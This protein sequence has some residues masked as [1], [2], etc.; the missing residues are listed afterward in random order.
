VREFL[1][2]HAPW[3]ETRDFLRQPTEAWAERHLAPALADRSIE[4]LWVLSA[5]GATVFAARRESTLAVPAPPTPE[6]LARAAGRLGPIQYFVPGPGGVWQVE[7]APVPSSGAT[8]G[9]LVVARRWDAAHVARLG[10][11]ADAV[12]TVEPAGGPG[13]GRDRGWRRALPD[14]DG[15]PVATAVFRPTRGPAPDAPLPLGLVAS[16]FVAFAGALLGGLAIA[17]NRWVLHPLRLV[18]RSLEG[19][20]P[21]P[22]APLRAVPGEFRAVAD[23]VAQA[24]EQRAALEQAIAERRRA[25]A[26]LR[27]S[28]ASLRES[29]ELRS[30]L[31]R[32][33]H[34]HVIQSI[35]A[36]GLGLESV[37]NAMSEDPFGA[38]GRLRHCMDNLNETIRQVR[39]YIS[40]LEPDPGGERQHLTEALR[41]LAETMRRLWPMAIE[42]EV[43]REAA[44]GWSNAAE[45]HALQIV[46]ESLSNALRH[47][48][49]GRVV[50]SLRR[51]AGRPVLRVRDDGAGFDPV[52]RLGTGR[53]LVN[54]ATRARE[55]GAELAVE[56]QPGAGTTVVVRLA[57]P[58]RES[59]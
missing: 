30:R 19:R 48:R 27:A 37:R 7:A 36:A 46:R 40:D 11:L 50:I 3:E 28:E 58:A 59:S 4:A 49:A 25:E 6:D 31:A 22:L 32:D 5:S 41:A 44:A 9:W 2:D 8:E 35:Y 12:V 26:A 53:G 17:L 24:F 55:M 14:L 56:S 42:L 23:L 47:G 39:G 18:T 38:E 52:Q 33:L 51:E 13:I 29:V 10:D 45:I 21:A 1:L 34:D 43:E 20:D 57:P 16:L 54:L 15:R